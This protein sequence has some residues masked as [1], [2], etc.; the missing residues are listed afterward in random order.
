MDRAI[1]RFR[2]CAAVIPYNYLSFSGII[3][4]MIYLIAIFATVNGGL[5]ITFTQPMA[6]ILCFPI[7]FSASIISEFGT[8]FRFQAG[9]VKEI[10][11]SLYSFRHS[12]QSCRIDYIWNHLSTAYTHIITQNSSSCYADGI[13]NLNF[14]V[15]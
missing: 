9:P 8:D 5:I 13:T 11:D 7:P 3:A 15:V 1:D 6:W 4:A 10:K 14:H 2:D 12:V